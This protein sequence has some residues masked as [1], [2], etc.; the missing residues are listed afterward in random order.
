MTMYQIF[1]E[2]EEVFHNKLFEI[3]NERNILLSNDINKSSQ[4]QILSKE[5]LMLEVCLKYI[6]FNLI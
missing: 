3:E 6:S 2:Q 1:K 5:K 4:I